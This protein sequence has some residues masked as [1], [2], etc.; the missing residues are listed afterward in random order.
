MPSPEVTVDCRSSWSRDCHF[1]AGP[2]DPEAGLETVA[3]EATNGDK[4]RQVAGHVVDRNYRDRAL[5]SA[6]IQIGMIVQS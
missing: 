5:G 6:T 4:V 3:G 1:D 2:T